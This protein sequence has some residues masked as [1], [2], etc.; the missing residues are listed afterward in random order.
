MLILNNL[1]D[2]DLSKVCVINKYVYSLC[3]DESFWA[4]RFIKTYEIYYDNIESIKNFKDNVSWKEYYLWISDLINDRNPYYVFAQAFKAG[5]FDVVGILYGMK[6]VVTHAIEFPTGGGMVQTYIKLKW[7]DT[8]DKNVDMEEVRKF[9]GYT[10]E[11][12]VGKDSV[13][14]YKFLTDP[15]LNPDTLKTQLIG[16]FTIKFDSGEMIEGNF[17]ENG[18]D[19]YEGDYKSYY[20]NGNLKREAYYVNNEKEREEKNF[21]DNGRYK[22]S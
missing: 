17:G 20:S 10:N 9:L 7:V 16:P 1:N 11:Q 15:N 19:H 6:H 13:T 18:W 2:E 8:I 12:D 3:Q 22:V 14:F 4:N 5:R 21:Y